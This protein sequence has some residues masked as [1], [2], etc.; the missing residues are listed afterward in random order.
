MFKDLIEDY[1]KEY[2]EAN[3]DFDHRIA[4]YGLIGLAILVVNATIVATGKNELG[5]TD[6]TVFLL[7]VLAGASLPF[8]LWYPLRKVGL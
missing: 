5:L 3:G 8:I 4:G 7:I 6:S 2:R 1:R